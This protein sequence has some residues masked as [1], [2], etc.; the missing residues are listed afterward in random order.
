MKVYITHKAPDANGE[1]F[2][3][4]T[5]TLIPALVCEVPFDWAPNGYTGKTCRAVLSVDEGD[6]DLG[7]DGICFNLINLVCGWLN[8]EDRDDAR[9]LLEVSTTIPDDTEFSK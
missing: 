7:G 2:A 4:L 9:R 5:S 3:F 6:L 8:S 1:G